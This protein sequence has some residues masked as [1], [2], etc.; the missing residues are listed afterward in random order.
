MPSESWK[1]TK[2]FLDQMQALREE[3]HRQIE[4]EERVRTKYNPHPTEEELQIG[5]F[6]EMLEPQVRDAIFTMIQKGYIPESS[7]F[8]GDNGETQMIDGYFSIDEEPKK[9]IEALGVSVTSDEGW[10][11]HYTHIR[12]QPD[13]TDILTITDRWNQIVA[14]LPAKEHAEDMSVSGGSHDFRTQYASERFDIEQKELERTL[15]LLDL[16][17]DFRAL[18]Q[19]RLEELRSSSAPPSRKEFEKRIDALSN[20]LWPKRDGN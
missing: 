13:T 2:S 4:E 8:A 17:P 3:I 19:E 6:R 1:P 7:G 5:A 9:K 11:P 15:R 16:H 12:F 14:L 10:G 18:Y 20:T